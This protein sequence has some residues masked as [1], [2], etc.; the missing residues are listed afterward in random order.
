MF[1]LTCRPADCCQVQGQLCDEGLGLCG[2]REWRA[3]ACAQ[4]E[5]PYGAAMLVRGDEAVIGARHSGAVSRRDR[6]EPQCSSAA[7]ER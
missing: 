4:L 7:M 1:W 5:T 6:A 2:L 3:Y